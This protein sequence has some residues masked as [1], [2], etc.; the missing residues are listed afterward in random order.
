MKQINGILK[1]LADG[2]IIACGMLAATCA[3][4]SAFRIPFLRTY[5]IIGCLI[6]SILLSGWMHLP[7]G[8]IV[9]GAAFLI[10]AALFGYFKHEQILF[11]FK[12]ILHAISEPLSYD[13]RSLPVFPA[14]KL[15]D[16]ADAAS[17][18]SAVTMALLVL[19]ALGGL[20]LAFSLIRG[21]TAML[22][23]LIPL[24]TFLLSLIYTDQP[25]AL[26]TVMSLMLYSAGALLGQGLRRGN[27]KQLGL[28]FALLVPTVTAFALLL[29]A[30]SPR[31]A[32]TPIPFEQR[33]QMLGDRAEA[34]GDT[35]L[36]VI[37]RN[38][39]RYQLDDTDERK[40][41]DAVAFSVQATKSGTYL[42]RAHS[43]GQYDSG[44]WLEAEEYTGEWN[45]MR[46]L[47]KHSRTTYET[48]RVR[49]AVTG[50][51]YV[52]YAFVADQSLKVGESFIRSASRT[53]YDWMI[54]SEVDILPSSS[55]A[56]ERA[57][58]AFALDQYTMPDGAQKDML[59]GIVRSAGLSDRGDDYLTAYA[60]A[61]YVRNSGAYT[62]TP[63]KP[64]QDRDFVEYFLTE[65]H[66]G[67][68]VHFASATT[69]LLQAMQIPARYTVGYRATVPTTD[70]W[71]DVTENSAHAWTEVYILGVG[72]VPLEST[73]GFYYDL[74][75]PYDSQ[76][77]SAAPR[78]TQRPTPVATATPS[79][80]ETSVPT[81]APQQT[82]SAESTAE[83]T[84]APAI[85]TPGADGSAGPVPIDQTTV[86][87]EPEKHGGVWWLLLVPMLPVVWIGVGMLIRT[88]RKNRFR[89]K[90]ARKA[91]ICILQ[92][93]KQLERFGVA[94]EPNA[95]ELEEEALFSNHPM[96]ETRKALLAKVQKIQNTL[97]RDK[98]VRRFFVKWILN[99]I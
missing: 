71:I 24:P 50:E 45:S 49:N 23:V 27:A 87:T 42:L 58:Y 13:F 7:R 96:T 43:Y 28:F 5:M 57:Y 92:Y 98:P 78:S 79:V 73:A 60:V 39:K 93:L 10:G 94:R 80:S 81:E 90:N 70:T 69:A 31:S 34:I 36:S 72:W 86:V 1:I 14:P 37:R 89:Q 53:A 11:G 67:F 62:L 74:G 91:V 51:R 48:I 46:A 84:A 12:W 61:S 66:K 76:T 38:P 22:T 15:P 41:N 63:G 99:K 8:G 35:L 52:P 44:V 18:P 25:P 75:S 6:A 9:P 95:Q 2:V 65:G 68:C 56:E 77:N 40:D 82:E 97:Y 88:R 64:P 33:K 16:G 83:P 4:P 17:I 30:V 21:K 3:L 54:R 26:W 47:G 19:A 29:L 55:S 85:P 20:L 59:L 32:F